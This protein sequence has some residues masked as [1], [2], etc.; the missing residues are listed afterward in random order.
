MLLSTSCMPH[1]D[2]N[3]FA[4]ANLD[5]KSGGP[6]YSKM[7]ENLIEGDNLRESFMKACLTKMGL[8][9]ATIETSTV[10]P[11][12]SALHISSLHNAEVSELFEDLR[13]DMT[14]EEGENFVKAENDTF[15]IEKNGSPLSLHTL[16][17][18]LPQTSSEAKEEADT[19]EPRSGQDKENID[20]N[21]VIKRLVFHNGGWPRNTET[22]N[23]NH[24]VF[25]SELVDYQD[26]SASRAEDFGKVLMY[27]DVVTSTNT[28][29]E[30]CVLI[31]KIIS[32]YC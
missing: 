5:A 28:L 11:V 17:V 4:A 32:E 2:S 23:F 6:D 24:D 20:Y 3:R 18:S 16:G 7:I 22:P 21:K 15:L 10:P 14:L 27:G 1:A 29:L 31:T 12:L 19:D 30:K 8:F 9:V 25:Y 13:S 26:E